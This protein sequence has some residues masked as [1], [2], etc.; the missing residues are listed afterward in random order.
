MTQPASLAPTLSATDLV[1]V[2]GHYRTLDQLT[3]G[4]ST[5][6]LADAEEWVATGLLPQPTYLLPDGIAVF[7]PDLLTLVDAAGSIEALPG[8][9]AT[10]VRTAL[11]AADAAMSPDDLDARGAEHWD[12]YLSGRYGVCLWNVTPEAMVEKDTLIA[13]IADLLAD[14]GDSVAW[15]ALLTTAVDDLDTHLRPFTDYDRL[16]WGGTSRDTYVTE[17]RRTHLAGEKSQARGVTRT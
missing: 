2:R 10:R 8:L 5:P 7:P 6:S 13:T 1:Y 16:R 15:R 4:R 3:A 17:V 12:G 11:E 14:P 9:F